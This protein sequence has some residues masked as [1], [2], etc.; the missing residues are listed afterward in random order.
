MEFEEPSPQWQT[1]VNEGQGL[2]IPNNWKIQAGAPAFNGRFLTAG[3]YMPGMDRSK[4][5][6]DT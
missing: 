6:P 5:E 4:T 1:L 3:S 2:L